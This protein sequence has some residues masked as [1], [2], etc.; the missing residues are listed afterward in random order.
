[1]RLNVDCLKFG[2]WLSYYLARLTNDV[3]FVRHIQAFSMRVAA[4]SCNVAVDKMMVEYLRQT[5]ILGRDDCPDL[6]RFN[7]DKVP[8]GV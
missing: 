8:R 2:H 4:P 3:E 7:R 5:S 6:V 1:M